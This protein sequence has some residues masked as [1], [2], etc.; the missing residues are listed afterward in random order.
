MLQ[1][2]RQLKKI[3]SSIEKKVLSELEKFKDDDFAKYQ[4]F[5][6]EF[7]TN[8]KYGVYANQQDVKDSVKNLLIFDTVN[9]DKKLTL[10]QY[11]D[12]MVEGQEAIYYIVNKT[13]TSVLS[14]PQMDYI[15]QKGYD[16]LLL[17]E[18]IDEFALKS[19]E[20][21]EEKKIQSL[22]STDLNLLNEE[23]KNKLKEVEEQKKNILEEIKK[24]LGDKIDSVKFS[25]HLVES[26]VCIVSGNDLSFDMEKALNDSMQGNR[27]YKAKKIL[28]I[29]P[30]HPLFIKLEDNLND[31]EA[32]TKIAKVLYYQALMVEGLKIE[33]PVE[34]TKLINELIL[35]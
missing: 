21:F 18:A 20:V 13:K 1:Q 32:F 19:L 6:K 12:A 28:E 3:A 2:D 7:G 31:N 27:G 34:Y 4:E 25:T 9:S 26:P 29:N 17:S 14:M 35:K 10:K 23:E 24:V 11:R 8:L 16:V 15:K 5:Y 22:S 33:D 30:N